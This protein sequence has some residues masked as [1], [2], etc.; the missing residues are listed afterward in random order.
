M[1]I[2]RNNNDASSITETILCWIVNVIGIGAAVFFIL[3]V[4]AAIINTTCSQEER[5]KAIMKEAVKNVEQY[6][7]KMK[8]GECQ[9]CTKQ[10]GRKCLVYITLKGKEIEE[11][12]NS[13]NEFSK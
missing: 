11:F 2:F 3:I 7:L 5:D 10:H 4:A 1:S 13:H 6:C 9:V 12:V 8:T